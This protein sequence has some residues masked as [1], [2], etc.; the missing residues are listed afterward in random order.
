MKKII[1]LAMAAMTILSLSS[2]GQATS[3]AHTYVSGSYVPDEVIIV[4][5]T[6]MLWSRTEQQITGLVLPTGSKVVGCADAPVTP[7]E[8]ELTRRG[9]IWGSRFLVKLPTANAA[10]IVH[11]EIL[12]QENAV[13]SAAYLNVKGEVLSSTPISQNDPDYATS[14]YHMKYDPWAISMGVKYQGWAHAAGYVFKNTSKILVAVLDAGLN[15]THQDVQGSYWINSGEIPNNN[16]DDD[17]NG[18]VDDWRGWDYVNNDNDPTDDYSGVWHGTHVFGIIAARNNNANNIC[19][20]LTDTMSTMVLKVISAGAVVTDFWAASGYY[21][22]LSKGARV[23]NMSFIFSSSYP[24]LLMS[25]IATGVTTYK[26]VPVAASGN[27]G[28]LHYGYPASGPDVL[29]VGNADMGGFRDA[30]S[31]YSDSLDIMDKGTSVISLSGGSNTAS[32]SLSG[33]SMASPNAAGKVWWLLKID[34][35]LTVPQVIAKMRSLGI[36]YPNKDSMTGYGYVVGIDTVCYK[37]MKP[38]SVVFAA[39]SG[40][41]ALPYTKRFTIVDSLRYGLAAISN[42]SINTNVLAPGTYTYYMAWKSEPRPNTYYRDTFTLKVTITGTA[43]SVPTV[44]VSP[45][46]ASLCTGSGSTTLT[47]TTNVV[48]GSYQWF[49]GTIPVGTNAATLNVTGLS[50][51]SYAYSCVV[52]VPA[53][54]CYASGSATSNVANVTV[55]T[56]TTPTVSVSASPSGSVCAGT[57]VTY[58]ATTSVVGGSYQWYVGTSTVGTGSATYTYTPS[59]G[60][61]VKCVLTVPS[62]GCYTSTTAT[63]NI[64]TMVVNPTVVPAVSIAASSS[65]ICSGTNVTFTAT[66]TNGGSSP[67]YQWKVNNGNVGTNSA[68]Y[69]STTLNNGDVVTCVLTSSATCLTSAAGTSNAITMTVNSTVSPSVSIAANPGSTVCTGT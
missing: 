28:T 10:Q 27:T 37:A 52:T 5:K 64:I 17:N 58:T 32:W 57:S 3:P 48:G 42:D 59:N 13:I 20:W 46:I 31:S 6:P 7:Q 49:Q 16:I 43:G 66:P 68:T 26:A 62:G 9:M 12:L 33:T 24:T 4:T 11:S 35:S 69:S 18:L 21:Y 25:A 22:A 34:S 44:T 14:Q 38:D 51:G 15:F 45:S 23:V 8:P 67:S 40:K 54:G 55:Q 56:S 39:C 2:Y 50:A 60:D 47:A 53:T 41:K 61:Q 36:N 63:S 29:T 65:V 19:G 1:M 30:S